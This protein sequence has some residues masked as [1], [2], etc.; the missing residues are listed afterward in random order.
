MGEPVVQMTGTRTLA[1]FQAFVAGSLIH[2]VIFG[3]KHD[4]N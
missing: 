3:V 2:I 1:L 4:A